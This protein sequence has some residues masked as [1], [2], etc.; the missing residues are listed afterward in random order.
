MM[1]SLCDAG[2]TCWWNPILTN[3]FKHAHCISN[4][5]KP[6]GSLK[7]LGF[8]KQPLRIRERLRNYEIRH[9]IN[10][11]SLAPADYLQPRM[12]VPQGGIRLSGLHHAKAR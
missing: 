12:A 10:L 4:Y 1:P 11:M 2:R 8:Y 7:A 3:V 9:C 5:W 6:N